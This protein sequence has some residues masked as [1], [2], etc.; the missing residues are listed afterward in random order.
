LILAGE[1]DTLI[2]STAA[3]EMHRGIRGSQLAILPR[4]GHLANL[5]RPQEFNR[6]LV[7]FLGNL[8]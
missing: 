8:A 5:E 7:H 6:A 3:E 4:C 1:E 2:P